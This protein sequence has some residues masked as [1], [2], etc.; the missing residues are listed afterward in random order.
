MSAMVKVGDTPSDIEEGLNA[1][2][3]TIGVTRTGNEVGLSEQ[4]W[5]GLSP[6]A[7][8]QALDRAAAKLRAAGAHYVVESVADCDS[9][10]DEIDNIVS[11]VRS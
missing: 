9:I 5:N 4:E 11:S 6:A 1:G 3:W 7:Q 2:M 8:A 10:L